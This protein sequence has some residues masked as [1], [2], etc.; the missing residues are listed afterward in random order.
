MSE[1]E[2]WNYLESCWKKI[3]NL[4][5]V[6]RIDYVT[7]MEAKKNKDRTKIHGLLYS[8]YLKL[9]NSSTAYRFEGWEELKE[10]IKRS[11]E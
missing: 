9:H 7:Y 8:I 3:E 1:I 2:W 6:Y 5:W 11:D 4:F 10:L